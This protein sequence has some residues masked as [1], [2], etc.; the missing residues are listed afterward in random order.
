MDHDPPN[1]I[2]VKSLLTEVITGHP[3]EL[4]LWYTVDSMSEPTLLLIHT[5]S[6]AQVRCG[7]L[8]RGAGRPAPLGLSCLA[9]SFPGRAVLLDLQEKLP[10]SADIPA[11]GAQPFAAVIVAAAFAWQ[12]ID[13]ELMRN[14]LRE[15][16]PRARLVLGGPRAAEVGTGWDVTLRGT[17]RVACEW[18]LKDPCGMNGPIDTLEADLRTP[19]SV[20]SAP[21]GQ[22][23]GYAAAAEK[24]SYLPAVS[25]H[26]PWLGLLDRCGESAGSP[27]RGD[28][29]DLFQW[30][31]K[32][33]FGNIS[34]ETPGLSGSRANQVIEIASEQGLLLSLP[35][36]RPEDLVAARLRS[37]P[38][39]LRIWLRPPSGATNVIRPFVD[40][41]DDLRSKG[42]S[43]GIRLPVDMLPEDAAPLLAV[44]DDISVEHPAAW[45]QSLLKS[46]LMAFYRHHGRLWRNLLKIRSGHDLVRTLRGMYGILDLA[47]SR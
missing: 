7:C 6:R 44:A 4:S 11:S 30:L 34:L 36:D 20:P 35:F 46:L 33:G 32:S 21:L 1:E 28:L 26:Q 39:L 8:A 5:A 31:K 27:T 10:E 41:A 16:F 24:A 29:A 9:A 25:F 43:V 23:A 14:R 18:L 13:A 45:Q 40:A 42:I 2:S 3:G 12:R 22:D 19:L 47:L 37:F 17:G 38:A 15:L